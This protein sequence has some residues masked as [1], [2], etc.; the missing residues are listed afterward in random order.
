MNDTVLHSLILEL[1]RLNMACPSL[2]LI[3]WCG[4]CSSPGGLTLPR[5]ESQLLMTLGDRSSPC[6]LRKSE[7]K[8][9]REREWEWEKER[10]SEQR[11][12]EREWA[13]R[14]RE[15]QGEWEIK[16]G[17]PTWYLWR[18]STWLESQEM[19]N[20]KTP[21]QFCVSWWKMREKLTKE[22]ERKR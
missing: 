15:R 12:R 10:E 13:E 6:E 14:K 18:R 9:E 8:R 17:E 2:S 11:E 3:W 1:F 20:Y 16:N 21:L 22:R 19:I 5:P 7:R 4:T